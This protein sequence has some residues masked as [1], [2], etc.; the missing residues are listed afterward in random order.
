VIY[1]KNGA[2]IYERA[3]AAPQALRVRASLYSAGATVTDAVVSIP[4]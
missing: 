1:T 2:R 3:L 4:R